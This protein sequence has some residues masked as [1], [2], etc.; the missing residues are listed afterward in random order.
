LY[1]GQPLVWLSHDLGYQKNR[2][3]DHRPRHQQACL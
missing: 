1:F 2:A 3:V